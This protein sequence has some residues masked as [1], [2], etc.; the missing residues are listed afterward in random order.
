MEKGVTEAK[1]IVKLD[2]PQDQWKQFGI[3]DKR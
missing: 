3:E 1:K 2:F